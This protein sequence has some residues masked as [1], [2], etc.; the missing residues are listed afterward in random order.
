MSIVSNYRIRA[1]LRQ[2]RNRS[3]IKKPTPPS[4]F[5]LKRTLAELIVIDG[6]A[7]PSDP[8]DCRIVFNDIGP[9]GLLLFSTQELYAGQKVAITIEKPRR[10]YVQGEVMACK[11]LSMVQSVI[12]EHHYDFRVAIQFRFQSQT[13]A[14]I[15]RNYCEY[16]FRHVVERVA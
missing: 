14:L 12:S 8:V 7:Q 16:L 4:P 1:Y 6:Y 13:E 11:R 10:F 2:F 3:S 9:N 5:H 15:V